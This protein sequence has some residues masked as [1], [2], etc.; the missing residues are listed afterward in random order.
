MLQFYVFLRALESGAVKDWMLYAAVTVAALY[1]H[2]F[3][4]I[5]LPIEGLYLAGAQVVGSARITSDRR[6]R[7]GLTQVGL[8]LG[9]QL[10]AVVVV[11]P[12][13]VLELPS[14]VNAGYPTLP[15]LGIAR[16]HQIL[17]VLI[18]LAPLNS[19][20]PAGIGQTLRTD[21]VVTLAAVG[22]IWSLA[23]RRMRVL[24]LAA[25]VLL[26][27]PLAWRA[28]QFGHYFWS[29]TQVLFVLFPLS[30]LAPLS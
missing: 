28:D 15:A 25:I 30:L 6:I 17:V 13:L 9:A 1:S 23:L 5:L 2:F 19:L 24:L 8:G 11:A 26:D 16:F 12:W 27:I 29:E 7:A 22:L 4:A 18:G 21:I 14:Q 10:A 20:P 3:L